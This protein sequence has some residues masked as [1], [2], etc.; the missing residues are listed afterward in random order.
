ME[1][2]IVSFKLETVE[3]NRIN[4]LRE[5]LF[6]KDLNQSPNHPNVYTRETEDPDYL[7]ERVNSHQWKNFVF[8]TI[9]NLM[10]VQLLKNSLIKTYKQSTK[11]FIRLTKSL[12]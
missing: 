1:R 11:K 3:S 12:R 4:R 2:V 7:I 6:R 10:E 9:H 5:L 8:S